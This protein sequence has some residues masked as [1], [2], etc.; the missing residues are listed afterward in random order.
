MPGS[1]SIKGQF[2]TLIFW[3]SFALNSP[4]TAQ[5]NNVVYEIAGVKLEMPCVEARDIIERGGFVNRDNDRDSP[6]FASLKVQT[7][8]R[9]VA[10]GMGEI[11]D[12]E[13]V[14]D[15]GVDQAF[16]KGPEQ[17]IIQCAAGVRDV[18]V[19]AIRYS[20]DGTAVTAGDFQSKLIAKYG[21]PGK[22]WK[23]QLD[24]NSVLHWAWSPGPILQ[25]PKN[26]SY[27]F[28]SGVDLHYYA[29]VSNSVPSYT[30]DLPKQNLDL[31]MTVNK[32]ASLQRGFDEAVKAAIQAKVKSKGAP[33]SF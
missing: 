13:R 1:D 22:I 19:E 18:Y 7:L 24:S 6:T 16:Q 10:Q 30:Y 17:I 29:F 8:E 26:L 4:A 2:V 14:G 15:I 9:R 25:D 31:G 20:I 27:L 3:T 23:N 32:R 21:P 33:T 5:G 12:N 11:P 28:P